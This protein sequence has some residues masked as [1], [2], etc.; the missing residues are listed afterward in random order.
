MFE[1]FQNLLRAGSDG[2]S[3][4][5][6][7]SW[8]EARS[9]HFTHMPESGFVLS[10]LLHGR[11]LRVEYGAPARLF[12][13]GRELSARAELALDTAATVVLM[14][15]HLKQQLTEQ[16][17]RLYEQVTDELQT[18]TEP[19]PEEMRWVSMYRDLGWEGPDP[20]FWARYAVLAD[21]ADTARHWV[22]DAMVA[23][24][25][26]WPDAGV[27]AQTPVLLML[28][29]G[30]TYLRMQVPSKNPTASVLYAL[31]LFEHASAQAMGLP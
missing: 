5:A 12:I 3:T 23:R 20:A 10:G 17:H 25:M 6:V 18:V 8:S 26:A 14:N 15:R 11:P 31:D 2:L 19:L 7:H 24:L 4:D 21:A 27:D 13:R 9:L 28:M 30:K 22:D 1:R 16:A 29:R